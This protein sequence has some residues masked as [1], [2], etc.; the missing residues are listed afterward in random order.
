MIENKKDLLKELNKIAKENPLTKQEKK[1]LYL[2]SLT[3]KERQILR[4]KEWNLKLDK[5]AKENSEVRR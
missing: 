2:E 5:T 1:E 4:A 3:P